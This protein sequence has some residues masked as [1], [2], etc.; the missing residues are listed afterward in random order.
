MRELAASRFVVIVT[1]LMLSLLAG[2]DFSGCLFIIA[3]FVATF[4]LFTIHSILRGGAN[5]PIGIVPVWIPE[6]FFPVPF[7][8]AWYPEHVHPVKFSYETF[9]IDIDDGVPVGVGVCVDT[10]HETDGVALDVSSDGW[11]VVPKIVVVEG[12]FGVEDLPWETLEVGGG[13]CDGVLGSEG[14]EGAVPDEGARVAL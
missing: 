13:S 7:P 11:V 9:G 10:A 6:P 14:E 1:G 12:G 3:L 4:G 2:V 8:R 5:P